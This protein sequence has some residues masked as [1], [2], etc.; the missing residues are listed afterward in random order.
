M[1]LKLLYLHNPVT[2][3]NTKWWEFIIILKKLPI[4]VQSITN[5]NVILFYIKITGTN[6]TTFCLNPFTSVEILSQRRKGISFSAP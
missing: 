6:S 5:T 2:H 3:C 1:V 4:R